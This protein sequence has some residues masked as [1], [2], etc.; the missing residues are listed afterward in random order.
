[1]RGKLNQPKP[2]LTRRRPRKSTEP[3]KVIIKNDDNTKNTA[4]STSSDTNQ[5]EGKQ[6]LSPKS[7]CFKFKSK[8]TSKPTTRCKASQKSAFDYDSDETLHDC[9]QQPEQDERQHQSKRK[10]SSSNDEKSSSSRYKKSQQALKDVESADNK[11]KRRKVKVPKSRRT[12]NSSDD[13]DFDQ[14]VKKPCLSLPQCETDILPAIGR[15]KVNNKT[16]LQ[17][18]KNKKTRNVNTGVSELKREEQSGKSQRVDDG[19][20][21]QDNVNDNKCDREKTG[22][23]VEVHESSNAVT[24]NEKTGVDCDKEIERSSCDINTI[25]TVQTVGEQSEVKANQ[26]V[27]SDTNDVVKCPLCQKVFVAAEGQAKVNEHVNSCIDSQTEDK[28]DSQQTKHHEHTSHSSSKTLQNQENKPQNSLSLQQHANTAGDEH[29]PQSSLTLLQDQLIAFEYQNRKLSDPELEAEGLFFC[30]ICQK[31]LSRMNTQ[32]RAQHIN[33]CCDEVR[34]IEDNKTIDGSG[35]N[36]VLCPFCAMEM[37]S[38][39]VFDPSHCS[40]YV[41]CTFLDCTLQLKARI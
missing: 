22:S 41:I 9:A 38:K 17:L 15:R 18:K 19:C 20:G 39:K 16:T 31:D 30:Q 32:R 5:K 28:N 13:E 6:T 14:P 7:K 12:G 2:P 40:K 25:V 21:Q 10:W 4:E 33:K 1:M 34:N 26:H 8:L 11:V 36:K 3:Q 37:K 29:C 27:G 24:R 35:N 23:N